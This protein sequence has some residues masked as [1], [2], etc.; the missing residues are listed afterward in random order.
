M[1]WAG[2]MNMID[3]LAESLIV[4]PGSGQTGL[5]WLLCNC[6]VVFVAFNTH[7]KISANWAGLVRV[8]PGQKSSRQT[9]PA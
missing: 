2:L 7:A 5:V 8:I 3:A 1:S 6:K 9:E 4:I